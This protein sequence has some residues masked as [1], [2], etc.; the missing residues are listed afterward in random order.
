LY[1]RFTARPGQRDTLAAVLL[2]A[3]RGA[4]DA[5]GCELYIVGISPTEADTVWVTEVWNSRAE[6]DASLT[7]PG[8]RALI[9]RAL[10]LLAGAPE[11]IETLP[12]GGKGIAGS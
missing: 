1:V 8:A 3:A 7:V 6:H 11:S 4:R 10:P 2:E 5:P 12:L 9:E